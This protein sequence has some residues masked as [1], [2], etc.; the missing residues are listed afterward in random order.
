MRAIVQ[1]RYGPPAGVFRLTEL[2]APAPDDGEVLVRV[3]ASAVNIGDAFVAQGFPYLLRLGF[4]LRRPKNPIPGGDFAGRV[5]AVGAGVMDVRPG[6]EVIGWT[7]GALAE[8][9]AA[10][11][12][13]V[14]P[15]PADLSFEEAACLGVS[16]MTALQA[17]RDRGRVKG[18]DRVLVNGASGGVGPFAVQIAKHLGAEVTAVCSARN[19]EQARSL[20]ADHVI[21]YAH[22]DYTRSSGRW[23][24]VLDV[25]GTRRLSRSRRVLTPTGRL[26]PIGNVRIGPWLGGLHRF[27]GAFLVS[28][29][30]RR[31]GRPFISLNNRA[32]LLAVSELAAAGAIR[33]VI[34]A[35]YPLPQAARA[36][37]HVGSRRA[38]AKVVI[39]V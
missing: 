2:G 16:A 21:D 17:V 7:N 38:R 34:E 20:G 30:N 37:E 25:A 11:A 1:D 4:G 15:K 33:P 39:S 6:D 24:V 5:E 13:Q 9:V 8:V 27:F 29:V 10:P 22:Q 23:D 14:V 36:Y 19:V 26:V 35:T 18:G 31:Q 12:G 3:Q 28:L 32:D